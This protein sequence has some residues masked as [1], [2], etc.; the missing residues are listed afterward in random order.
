[1]DAIFSSS[2]LT[3]YTNGYCHLLSWTLKKY[4]GSRWHT[5]IV[6]LMEGPNNV[7]HS[8]I[9]VSKDPKQKVFLDICG[10]YE[11]EKAVL[12][13]WEIINPSKEERSL[14]YLPLGIEKEKWWSD[15]GCPYT[16]QEQKE[17]EE[18]VIN[19]SAN[20]HLILMKEEYI[21]AEDC[22]KIKEKLWDDD[23]SFE[24]DVRDVIKNILN[25]N[26]DFIHSIN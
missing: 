23:A 24:I 19:H 15:L 7:V 8:L 21:T 16:I 18:F 11:S 22:K 6:E 20:F 3:K 1:M 12:E 10:K 17:T 14:R 25:G 5:Q 9:C 4:F 13:I 26:Y 2:D